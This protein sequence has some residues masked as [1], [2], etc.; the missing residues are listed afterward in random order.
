MKKI[1]VLLI[2]L[3]TLITGCFA[4]VACRPSADY[5]VGVIQ[6]APHNALDKA[7][8]AFCNKLTELMEADGNTV[9]FLQGNANG[10]DSLNPSIVEG[11]IGKNVD[12]I[13]SIATASSQTAVT[14]AKDFNIPVIFN[15]VTDPVDAGLVTSMTAPTGGNVTG[16]SDINPIA[17]QV[18]LMVELMGGG[19]K[20]TVGVLYASNESNSVV[21][22]DAVKAACESKGINFIESGISDVINIGDGL[23]ALAAADIVYLPTDNLLANNAETVHAQNI[24]KGLKLP[25]VCG[26]SG[27]TE[28]CGVATLSVNYSYLGELAA[29]MAYD[30]LTGKKSAGDISVA[31]QTENYDYIVNSKVAEEVG[32]S[33]PQSVIDKA[34]ASK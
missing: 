9:A 20:F 21:Q 33:I 34:N 19:N 22:K 30:I 25:I 12:L 29:Q 7:N 6:L 3:V 31:S 8:D 10:D 5:T 26:E 28:S 2:V 18:D 17:E 14:K 16:V 1:L 27:M 32:F 11:Y 4:L 23:A 24:E 13:Y 15:A